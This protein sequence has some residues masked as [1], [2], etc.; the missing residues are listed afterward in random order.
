MNE[1]RK[2]KHLHVEILVSKNL[3]NSNILSTKTY[4]CI[5]FLKIYDKEK[6]SFRIYSSIQFKKKS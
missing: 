1:A 2:F 3:K 6:F 4:N 5:L